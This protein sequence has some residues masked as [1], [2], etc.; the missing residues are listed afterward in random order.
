[1]TRVCGQRL[2]VEEKTHAV[3]N[4]QEDNEMSLYA[5]TYIELMLGR[6][7]VQIQVDARAAVSLVSEDLWRQLLNPAPL[8][9]C[10]VKLKAYCGAPL[11]VKIL[12]N[13]LVEYNRQRTI[14]P[15]V[16]VPGD[17]PVLSGRDWIENRDVDSNGVHTV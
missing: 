2:P 6:E 4:E 8:T 17:Q 7:R 15:V 12:D 9:A 5:V 14:M 16:M 10:T 3:A 1:M 11:E 13:V